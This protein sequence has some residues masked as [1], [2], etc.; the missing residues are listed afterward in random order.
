MTSGRVFP[1]VLAVVLLG[2]TLTNWWLL[3]NERRGDGQ[4]ETVTSTARTF[5]VAL[6]NFSADTIDEDVRKLRSFAVGD[7]ATQVDDTFSPTRIEQI[8]RAK[9]VSTSQVRS[10][11][12]ESLD[13]DQ[14]KVFAVVDE[15]VT[16]NV[17]SAPRTDVIRV[18]LGMI[19]T[20]SGWKVNSVD[21]LQSPGA[22]GA[23]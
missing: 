18:E 6:T 7:F 9:V 15:K 12:I 16:N 2:T 14:A 13:G 21:I 4:V 8:K 17:S 5:L 3:P 11:F 23:G 19:N 1:W 10:V 20:T 22:T